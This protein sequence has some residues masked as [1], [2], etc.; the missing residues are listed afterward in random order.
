LVSQVNNRPNLPPSSDA[1]RLRRDM[2]TAGQGNNDRSRP[3][4]PALKGSGHARPNE[5][6]ENIAFRDGATAPSLTYRT[7]AHKLLETIGAPA[8]RTAS[9]AASKRRTVH[10]PDRQTA[11]MAAADIGKLVRDAR[12][13][14]GMTQQRFADLAGVGRR[15]LSELEGGKASL[16]IG[17]VLAVCK[18]AGI[19]LSARRR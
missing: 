12:K 13:E 14:M 7:D 2:E 17:L 11:I 10:Q 19:D 15:F 3:V 6:G 9:L 16:E 8:S 5:A 4:D 18:A 1:D